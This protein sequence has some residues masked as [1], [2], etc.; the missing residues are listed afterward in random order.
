MKSRKLTDI[1][2]AGSNITIFMHSKG[3]FPPTLVIISCLAYAM[4]DFDEKGP[5]ARSRNSRP[6]IVL[7]IEL[8]K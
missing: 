7:L 3:S 1:S 6:V 5:A 2:S 4:P 8:K